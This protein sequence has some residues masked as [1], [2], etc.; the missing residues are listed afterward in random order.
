[1]VGSVP[2]V[3]C[4]KAAGCSVTKSW[5]V[6]VTHWL[7][8]PC[9]QV[10]AAMAMFWEALRRRHASQMP[11]TNVHKASCAVRE[12][13]QLHGVE[14]E[15]EEGWAGARHHATFHDA[16]CCKAGCDVFLDGKGLPSDIYRAYMFHCLNGR[17]SISDNNL[18]VQQARKK[19]N[20]GC[21]LL[22][23]FLPNTTTA[24]YHAIM[25]EAEIDMTSS[26]LMASFFSQARR[27]VGNSMHNRD[28]M[29]ISSGQNVRQLYAC[30]QWH[31]QSRRKA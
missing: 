28:M 17:R 9:C 3:L 12:S 20:G 30:R 1:M 23:P 22:S 8:R 31:A 18:F 10:P 21:R 5:E 19:R 2:A 25:Q 16:I 15:E 27:R 13:L 11:Q 6:C 4:A 29:S 7:H 14:G 24:T 26:M